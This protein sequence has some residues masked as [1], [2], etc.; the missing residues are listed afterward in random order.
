MA[1]EVNPMKKETNVYFKQLEV[2]EAIVKLA[3]LEK[4]TFS[5]MT[6]LLCEEAIA[7]RQKSKLAS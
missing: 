5:D 7:A 2:K 1:N 4:R 3:L 6:M